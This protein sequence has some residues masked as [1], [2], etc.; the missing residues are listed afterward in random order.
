MNRLQRNNKILLKRNRRGSLLV[1]IILVVVILAVVLTAI[2]QSM[3]ISLKSVSRAAKF[4]VGTFLAENKMF[5]LLRKGFVKANLQ[6]SKTFDEPY[7]EY[8]SDVKAEKLPKSD[9]TQ[10]DLQIFWGPE[11]KPQEISLSTYLFNTSK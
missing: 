8:R 5:D 9:L 10:V 2:I 11:R 6:E 3:S 1:E 7:E 4:T